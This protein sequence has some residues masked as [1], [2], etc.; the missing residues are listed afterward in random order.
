M[1]FL[2]TVE[3]NFLHSQRTSMIKKYPRVCNIFT[4]D[5]I[6]SIAIISFIKS[7]LLR[8]EKKVNR[9]YA[10][11]FTNPVSHLNWFILN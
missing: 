2:K 11:N 8:R 7:I 5:L 6:G 9:Y 3:Y 4:I 1:N 10:N